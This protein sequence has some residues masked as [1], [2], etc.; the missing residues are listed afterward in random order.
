MEISISE[1]GNKVFVTIKKGDKSD[2]YY[3]KI[4]A[5]GKIEPCNDSKNIG[6]EDRIENIVELYLD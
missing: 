6:I 2:T 5:C 3:A 1:K 4:T